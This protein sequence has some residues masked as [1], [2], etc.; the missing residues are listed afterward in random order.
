MVHLFT[1]RR[2]LRQQLLVMMVPL[3][4]TLAMDPVML[5]MMSLTL[6]SQKRSN[7]KALLFVA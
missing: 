4:V 7:L 2:V 3:L 1:N 6:N 5:V